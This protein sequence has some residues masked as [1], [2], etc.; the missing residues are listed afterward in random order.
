[1]MV[2]RTLESQIELVGMNP[3]LVVAMLVVLC[4]W[5]RGETRLRVVLLLLQ[6]LLQ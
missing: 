3:L 6:G 2:S 1:M 5:T 4:R